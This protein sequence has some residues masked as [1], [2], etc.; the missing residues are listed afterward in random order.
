[1][2]LGWIVFAMGALAIINFEVF[3]KLIALI[4]TIS[5]GSYLLV[6]AIVYLSE[7]EN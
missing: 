6:N 5:A 7:K 4:I 3:L 1:M 2:S